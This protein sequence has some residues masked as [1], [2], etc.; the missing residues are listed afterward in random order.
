MSASPLTGLG[1]SSPLIA[2]PMA[3]G[4]S[5]TALILAAARVG[6][7]GFVGGGYKSP[8]DLVEQIGAV[9]AE[10]V[11]FGVNLFAPNPVPVDRDAFR[12]Y[13]EVVRD[14]AHRYGLEL[15]AAEPVEDDD[16]W[17]AKVAALLAD[18]VPVV[19]FTFGIPDQS[20]IAA[21]RA[22]GTVVVQTVTGAA[23]A[24][25]AA[26]AGVDV[27]AVQAADAGGHSATLTP[28]QPAPPVPL[29]ELLQ[30]VRS[31]T[32]LPMIAAGGLATPEAVAQ[33]LNAGAAA[34]MVGTALLLADE[35]GASATHKAALADH[36]RGDTVLT[37]A[38]TGRPAR[39]LPNEFLAR[40][41]RQA[42]I[43]YPAVHHLTSP[44]RR[45]AAAA[46]DPERL[47]LW[48]GAGYRH[49]VSA[50]AGEILTQ[51]ARHV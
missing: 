14:E 42:P 22:A 5:T 47:H 45:A 6:A 21:L 1:L 44:M 25:A 15:A 35:S 24:R 26:D 27:L 30:S 39:A 38:F 4:P 50:P 18:P 7:L 9:R 23:E 46:G 11:P 32:D 2:A 8:A 10:G 20:T 49:S 31:T 3:G 40:H 43:G 13:A 16:A 29:G 12:A 17:G 19:S 34:A 48:A 37:R 41:D 33:A 36:S 51:L 28:A